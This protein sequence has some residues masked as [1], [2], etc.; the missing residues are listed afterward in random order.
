MIKLSILKAK[1]M[2]RR[3][4]QAK[5]KPPLGLKMVWISRVKGQGESKLLVGSIRRLGSRGLTT[6]GLGTNRG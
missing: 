5:G 6:G 4:L 2:G 1:V 3:D